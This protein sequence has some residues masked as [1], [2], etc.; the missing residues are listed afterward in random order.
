MNKPQS[1]H[2]TKAS[3]LVQCFDVSFIMILC[4]ATL[5]TTMIVHG[6]V[7]VGAG[8]GQGLD[9]S[10]KASTFLLVAAIFVI[11]MWYM[12]RHSDREL[13]DLVNHIYGEKT[14]DAKTPAGSAKSDP[15]KAGDTR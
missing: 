6:K 15:S 12:L 8:S 10:F 2:R 7:L 5:L 14:P 3:F 4:F 9:H 13:G 11:Y 1:T